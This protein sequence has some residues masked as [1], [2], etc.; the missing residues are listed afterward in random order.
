[1]VP[2]ISETEEFPGGQGSV[3]NEPF[4]SFM[5]PAA[6]LAQSLKPEFHAGKALAHQPWVKAPTITNAR[7]GLGPIYNART[8]LACHINGGRGKMPND[9]SEVLFSAFL[10]LSIPGENKVNGVVSEP[11][12][13][14][15]LQSQSVSL[16]HQLRTRVSRSDVKNPDVNPEA[17]VY[18][19]WETKTFVYPDGKKI[20]LRFPEIDIQNLGYG[21]MH[22]DV[23]MGIRVAPPMQGVGLLEAIDQKDIDAYADPDDENEDGI[24]GRINLVWDFEANKTVPGRFGLKANKSSIRFQTA[25]AFAGD[26][27]ITNPVFPHESCTEKQTICLQTPN[28]NDISEGS[29]VAVE[30]PESLLKLVVNFTKN[31]GVPKRRNSSSPE[32]SDGRDYFY[33]I[34]CH[35]CHR[36][37]YVTR[38]LTDFPHLSKQTIWP[39]TDLLLHD[40]GPELGDRRPDYLATGNEWRTPPLW[41]V[42]LGEQVN[43]S[44]NLLHDGRA[45]SVE[46]AIIWHGGEAQETRT[47]FVNLPLKHRQAL[48][49]FVE[50]L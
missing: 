17:Y 35:Q 14:D 32:V 1:M 42:G 13:G 46:E 36:P 29:D 15:Q 6:N 48:I 9:N 27:G 40:M 41:G 8:C 21:E 12:Y 31:L 28:G 47:R 50:S 26:M 2:P 38:Q 10:R 20:E 39:Y 34:G 11:T 5:K 25:G 7:D 49:A 30:L 44:N 19:N 37:S 4:P 23:L 3:S 18:V 43:G 33:S 24:S 45:Q 16:A 22:T